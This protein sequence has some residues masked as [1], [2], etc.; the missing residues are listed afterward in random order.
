MTD[1]NIR[2][3]LVDDD[4]DDY[5]LTR[6]YFTDLGES[7]FELEWASTYEAGLA[8]IKNKQHHVYLLDYRLGERDGLELLQRA[9]ALGIS[10]PI[11]LLTSQG[12]RD[13]DLQVMEMGASDYL[14][15]S[16]LTSELLERSIRYAL[17]RV[18]TEEDLRESEE[19][20]RSLSENAPD[21][22]YTL[23]VEGS[24]TYVNPAWEE[25]VG[26]GRDETLGKY[27]V[28]FMEEKDSGDHAKLFKVIRDG[29]KIVRSATITLINK[30]GS[31]R[32][33]NFS[34]AP[35][36]N[37][38]GEI[39]GMVGLLKDITEHRK[40][41]AQLRQAQKMEAIG[42]L[43]GGIA[44]DFNNIL[45][46][47]IG[48]ADLAKMKLPGDSEVIY[49]LNQV[50]SAGERAKRLIQQ[51]L[52]F[53][54]MGEQQRIALSITPLIK[55]ALKFLKSTLPTSIEIRD[56]LEADPGIIEAD[57]TQIQ[58]IVMNLCTNAEHAMR[59]EGGTL[60]VKLIRVE[61]DRQTALQHHELHT[62]PH[63]RLTV[64]DTGCGMEPETL[65]HIFDP[66][67]T[68]KEV[69]EG[70]GLGLSV[71]HGIVNTHGGA[72]TVKS[73]PG[74]GTTF[75]V[76]FPI[77]EKE[78]K[79]Q[80]RSEGPLPTGNERILFVDDEQVIVYIGE[81]T[82]GQLGYDVVTKAN[83][84]DALELFRADPDRFDLVITDMTMPRMTGDQFARELI[85]LRPDIPIIL[86][87]GFSPK[88][89]KEQAGKIGI[90]AFV[91]KPL[92]RRDMANIV[93]KVLDA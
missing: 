8:A 7:R 36:L 23:G 21:I 72:I 70:T 50:K 17:E 55:E 34:G 77:I 29:N 19:K 10:A 26:Y 14:N 40:T 90:K 48:H 66:Y 45:M 6:D 59:E 35:N 41:E 18:H 2:I 71:V 89:S 54:R 15:K 49:N 4:E 25:I 62:G 46:A 93:R 38:A 69:G 30:D 61:V 56:Y 37:L 39:T 60:H 52:A 87:T 27:F 1:E 31:P 64:T 32:L 86:C 73:E 22:I 58:Q 92:V 75:H 84:V 33:F 91:M 44:H 57:A 43:A 42:T 78:E 79:L 3:L 81:K 67:F 74:K 51:I 85:K 82:L 12:D 11:I 28:D 53:S 80:E 68:T 88:I 76:Y 13:L 20:F 63:V 16:T 65:E 83:G 9:V 47:I 24:F 5:I